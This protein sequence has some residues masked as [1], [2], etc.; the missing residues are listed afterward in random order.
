MHTLVRTVFARLHSLDPEA[1]EKKLLTTEESQGP[2]IGIPNPSAELVVTSDAPVETDAPQAV[3]E[4]PPAAPEP[5]AESTRPECMN[6]YLLN[7]NEKLKHFLQTV[8]H[9][10]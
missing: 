10:S 8:S 5:P 7:F 4:E 1:E 3:A 9:P 6:S 2:E